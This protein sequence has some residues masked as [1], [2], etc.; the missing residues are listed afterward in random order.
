MSIEQG[1]RDRAGLRL[2]DRVRFD[3]LGRGIEARVTSVR[4]VDWDDPRE[5][6]FMFV[7]RPGLLDRA[8]H[9]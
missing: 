1:L 2:G 4:D 5:G 3:I 6:G 7:F 9:A 8:P